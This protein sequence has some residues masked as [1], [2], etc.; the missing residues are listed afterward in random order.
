MA[1]HARAGLYNYRSEVGA[2]TLIV[3]EAPLVTIAAW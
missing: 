2:D 3:S 1:R